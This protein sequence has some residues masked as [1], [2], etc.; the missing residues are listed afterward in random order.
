MKERAIIHINIADFAVAVERVVDSRL[1]DW[2]VII[3]PEGAARATVYDMSEEAY[4]NGVRKQMAL[5]RA[6]RYCPDAIVIPPHPDRYERAMTG[7]LKHT[8]PYSP[9][10]EMTDH[11]G[12]LFLDASGT[13]RLFGPP[14][15]LAT[16]IRR[17][18]RSAMGF[19]PV[20]SVAANKLVAKVAT[21]IVKPNGDYIVRPG[22][23][24]G[25][26][27]PLPVHLIPGIEP[28]DLLQLRDF[29][30][31]RAGQVSRLSSDQLAVAFGKR[32]Q[33]LYEA[34]RGIDPSPVLPVNQ[35]QPQV[36]AGHSFG[37]DT[38]DTAAVTGTLY[39]LVEQVGTDLRRRRLAA[40]RAA[41]I[42]DYSDG[43]RIVRQA[44]VRPA[45]ANDLRLFAV[46]RQ[47][48]S[49]AWFRRVRIRNLRLLCDR[50]TYPPAQRRLFAEDENKRQRRR[51]LIAALD[52]VRS[53]FG[54][55][56]IRMGRTLAA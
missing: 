18:V 53:R 37:N 21:R 8:L 11:K 20:W 10:I 24:A 40:R 54:T 45:T 44:A 35:K 15:D 5:R 46:A 9:L 3:A 19:D 43:G 51:N 39:R 33:V 55:E 32:S 2:P 25:F 28:A 38:N 41:I 23:E 49:R 17:N 7:L 13:G 36:S 4:Q 14:P 47:V 27:A 48:L 12:H 26:L 42:L 56:A 52:A 1:R 30:L 16:R 31:V 34:V 50:L 6:L 22:E 29:N